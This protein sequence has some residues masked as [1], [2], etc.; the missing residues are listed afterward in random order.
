MLTYYNRVQFGPS[1]DSIYTLNEHFCFSLDSDNLLVTTRHG[2]WIILSEEE[3][4]RLKFKAIV[5][6]S[7]LFRTLEEVGIILTERSIKKIV[8][9]LAQRHQ[10]LF[11]YPGLNIVIITDKCNLNC[12]Y[13]HP[14]ARPEKEEMDEKTARKVLDFIFTTPLRG[15]HFNIEGGEPLLRWEFIKFLYAEAQKRA[16][17]KGIRLHFSFGTNLNLMNEKIARELAERKGMS[18]CTSLDGPK[19]L[20][21]LQRPRLGGGGSYDQTVYW[22]KRL[23]NEFEKKIH[24]LPVVTKLSLRFGPEAL[25]DEYLK[26]GQEMVFFKPFRP[27][28]RALLNLKE[29]EMEPEDFYNF[30]Q[31]GA[32]YCLDLNKKGKKIRERNTVYFLENILSNSPV[33]SMC[34]RKPCGAGLSQLAYKTDGTICGCDGA[35]SEK[36]LDLGHVDSDDFST[37][38]A[39]SLPLIGIS[40][41]SVP[42]CSSCPFI[43]Y[44]NFCFIETWIQ[45]NII[46]P[47]IPRSFECKWRKKAFRFLFKKFL[48]KDQAQIL[49][50]WIGLKQCQ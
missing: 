33:G 2:G 50:S 12:L 28:G 11:R 48:D 44:C 10:F 30:W 36:F 40:L 45:E 35:R 32:E 3:Y 25:V 31:R 4:N 13:C 16:Q 22:M 7:E 8:R 6:D 38:R 15:L 21:D 20:H 42:F 27:T 49:Q 34:H 5:R 18:V 47:K 23:N 46:F 9:A 1:T 17:A 19:E 41:D 43:A 14:D 39:K 29:L 37:I 26:M 24:A